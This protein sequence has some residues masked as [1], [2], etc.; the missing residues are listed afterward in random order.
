VRVLIVHFVPGIWRRWGWPFFIDAIKRAGER[1]LI[2]DL[3]ERVFWFVAL[4][5]VVVRGH[6]RLEKGPKV[7]ITCLEHICLHRERVLLGEAEWREFYATLRLQALF[8]KNYVS[9]EWN[10]RAAQED[11]R[12]SHE[13]QE[14]S[15][16]GG[17]Q[18]WEVIPQ[19]KLDLQGMENPSTDSI[20]FPQADSQESNLQKEKTHCA[21]TLWVLG[22]GGSLRD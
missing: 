22:G 3:V 20:H 9:M 6:G 13:L 4:L 14:K 7:E 15:A 5:L 12:A 21:D 19:G 2:I 1:P 17:W 11:T 18:E 16:T 10:L 8:R